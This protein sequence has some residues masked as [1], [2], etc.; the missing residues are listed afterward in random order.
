MRKQRSRLLSRTE[1]PE[2]SHAIEVATLASGF[3][4][5]VP[6]LVM[7]GKRDGPNIGISATIHGD[8]IVGV[9]VIRE[10]WKSQLAG[11]SSNGDADHRA[12]GPL[13]VTLYSPTVVNAN[14]ST[15]NAANNSA[16]SFAPARTTSRS[17][18]SNLAVHASCR[19]TCH[20]NVT[21]SAANPF[22]ASVGKT[23]PRAVNRRVASSNLARGA[24]PFNQLARG[25]DRGAGCS[26]AAVFQKPFRT[27]HRKLLNPHTK[28]SAHGVFRNQMIL[29]PIIAIGI[30]LADG[31]DC[32]AHGELFNVPVQ[33]RA[34]PALFRTDATRIARL[35]ESE[36]CIRHSPARRRPCRLGQRL[37][38]HQRKYR[39]G[40]SQ[41]RHERPQ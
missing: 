30:G 31:K 4:L 19:S 9:Q 38:V 41:I 22:P 5:S 16:R 35:F 25:G 12:L 34:F 20:R 28:K 13:R 7:K 8:D 24:N 15:P 37:A 39:S 23:T 6:V 11:I 33:F 1:G 27:A 36:F 2:S 40:A 29:T 26:G 17:K 18:D 14:A 32:N 21:L 10:L 3:N